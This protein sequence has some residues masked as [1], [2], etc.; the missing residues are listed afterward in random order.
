MSKEIKAK[1]ENWPIA[2]NIKLKKKN[3]K[4][5]KKSMKH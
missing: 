3:L 4:I 2:R 1:A 5:F